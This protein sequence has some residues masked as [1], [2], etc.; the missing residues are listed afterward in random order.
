MAFHP[1]KFHN[2]DTPGKT[3]DAEA[4]D[5]VSSPE[6]QEQ[7]AVLPHRQQTDGCP[8]GVV[9]LRGSRKQTATQRLIFVPFRAAFPYGGGS[10]P[11][12]KRGLSSI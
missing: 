7:A 11:S 12:A 5:V 4:A 3:E 10:A 9:L 2:I 6:N 1:V 8:E